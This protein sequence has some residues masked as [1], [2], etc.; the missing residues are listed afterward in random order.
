MTACLCVCLSS[1]YLFFFSFSSNYS[2]IALV[3]LSPS[4]LSILTFFP[5]LFLLSPFTLSFFFFLLLYSSLFFFSFLLLSPYSLISFHP[6]L[7]SSFFPSC[8]SFFISFLSLCHLSP[9]SLLL[10]SLKIYVF[11]QEQYKSQPPPSPPFQCVGPYSETL[12]EKK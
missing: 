2:F 11:L 6:S 5:S 7:S 3:L 8:H 10:H 1:F 12:F 9:S 4:N